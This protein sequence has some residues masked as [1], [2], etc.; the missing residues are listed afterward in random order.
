[1]PPGGAALANVGVVALLDAC[2]PALLNA[3]VPAWLDAAGVVA[4]LNAGVLALLNAMA[5]DGGGVFAV[6]H[7]R[8]R[9]N[10]SPIVRNGDCAKLLKPVQFRMPVRGEIARNVFPICLTSETM[11]IG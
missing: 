11:C 7:A 5:A 3:G 6:T 8:R 9:N 2:V 4:L 10:M 1:M